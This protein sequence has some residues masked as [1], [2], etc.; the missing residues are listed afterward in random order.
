MIAR[1]FADILTVA[2]VLLTTAEEKLVEGSN[3][4]DTTREVAWAR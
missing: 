4:N 1:L 3:F 2:G